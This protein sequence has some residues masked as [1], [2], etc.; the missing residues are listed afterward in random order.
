MRDENIHNYINFNL[1]LKNKNRFLK[2]NFEVKYVLNISKNISKYKWTNDSFSLKF[3][4][5]NS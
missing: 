3:A 2:A 4:Y 1:I 5:L